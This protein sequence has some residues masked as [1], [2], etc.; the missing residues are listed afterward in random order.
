MPNSHPVARL[1]RAVIHTDR[2]AHNMRLLQD[3]VGARSLWPCIKANAYG[4][5]DEIIARELLRL[6][7][8]TFGVADVCEAV[9]L[10]EEGIEATF[11]VLS[12]TLPEHAEALVA[13]GCEPIV[14]T[15]DTVRALARAADK[16][17]RRVAVHVN[18]DTG[19][20]RIGIAPAEVGAFLDYCK[21]YPSIE[22]RGIMSHF[23]RAD[24]AD[25]RDALGQLARFEEVIEIARSHEIGLRHM[26]NSAA[27]FDIPG[28]HFDAARPGISIYGLAPSADIANP[29][30]R[31]LQPILEWRTRITFLKEAPRGKGL[32][33][34]HD[35]HTERPSLIATIP[36]GYGDGFSRRLSNDVDVLIGGMR[37]RQVGRVTMD[38]SLVDVT[39]L[40]GRVSLGDEVVVIGR[41]GEETITADEL[42]AKLG[43]INYEIVTRIA[44]RVPRVAISDDD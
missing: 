25:K 19:M 3:I 9:A 13:H 15:P 14:C 16:L 36:I 11:I 26:A 33:Y 17:G 37:C 27:I 7:Y 29:R 34:G 12:N 4:H 6:G 44:E 24:E 43:T 5:A 30:V 40:R 38:M 41:Q 32:S 8:D 28:S 31:D 1:T 10:I 35:F 22:I 2:L 18:V 20:G 42:A 21:S 23:A 39:P